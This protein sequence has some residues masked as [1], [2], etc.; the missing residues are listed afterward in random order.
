MMDTSK[1]VGF[2]S[3]YHDKLVRLVFKDGTEWVGMVTGLSGYDKKTQ[4][5]F[6]ASVVIFTRIK[7]L[8]G[9]Y[10]KIPFFRGRKKR[11]PLD[12]VAEIHEMHQ[13]K[14]VYDH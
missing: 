13:P 7:W 5:H 4:D 10:K 6:D 11:L 12:E 14:W 8:K 3:C 2:Y 9:Y 1:P